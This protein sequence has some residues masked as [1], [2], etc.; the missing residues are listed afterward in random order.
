MSKKLLYANIKIP[1]ELS[2]D[3]SMNPFKDYIYVE[4]TECLGLP[5]IKKN[6]D[7]SFV[8][9]KLTN[10]MKKEPEKIIETKNEEFIT[11]NQPKTDVN[12]EESESDSEFEPEEEAK[13]FISKDD[14]KTTHTRPINS[15]FK[16]RQFKHRHTTKCHTTKCH[17]T[18][19]N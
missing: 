18:K 5:E 2:D 17:T 11:D 10:F 6:V 3:G 16:K 1:V 8:M 9:S 15:S 14:I 12:M 19:H 13:I 4:F 7:Y